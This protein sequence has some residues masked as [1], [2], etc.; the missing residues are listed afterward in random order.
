MA[1]T[2]RP[3]ILWISFE[4]SNPRF[5]CYGDP[6]ART[7]NLDALAAD[8]CV[9]NRCFSTTGVSAPSRAAII[10]GMYPT[11]AG[12][13]H[14]RTSHQ[15]KA[16]PEL[17]TPYNAVLPHYAKCFT[18]YLRSAGYYCSNNGKHDYQF[19]APITAWDH[20]NEKGTGIADWQNR[21][22]QAK[23]QPFFAV[24]NLGDT[25]ESRMWPQNCPE[26]TFDPA[27]MIVPPYFPDTLKVREAMA[28][29]YTMIEYNDGLLGNL[30][31]KL[32]ADGLTENT[33]VFV[34]SDH[35]PMPRGKRWPYDAGIHVPLIARWPGHIEKGTRN[36]ELVSTLDLGPTMLSMAGVDIPTHMQGRAFLGDQ[37]KA[38]PPREY[39]HA[40]R[41][42]YDTDYD[43][44]RAVRDK[45]FKYMRNYRPE[46]PY[47]IWVP[48]RNKHPI[49]QEM[50]RLHLAGELNEAQSVMFQHPRPP[51]ELYDT[52]TDPHEINNLAKD[53]KFAPDLQ[54]LRGELM[55]WN[56]EVGDWGE[57][58]EVE[59]VRSWKPDNVTLK[60]AAPLFIP[61]CEENPGIDPAPDGGTFAG[62]LMLQLYAATQGASIAYTFDE[63]EDAYWQ[64]Y[65][66]PFLL[67]TGST[68]VRVQADRIGYVQSDESMATFEVSIPNG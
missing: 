68:T 48:Y 5:G 57:V 28:R 29:M 61:I 37:A 22:E 14:M 47:L 19:R 42:R 2:N 62:P 26:I 33:A 23:D 54:R 4:D 9:W 17:P 27:D 39:I 8:G 64:L 58:P 11:S 40:S 55:R 3:N 43:M 52:Q 12:T 16:T 24:Y 67:P 49:T 51:E 20:S 56:E 6:V 32:D 30:L 65:A 31:K 7:P 13:L 15:D 38:T 45:R 35:G 53:P 59:M 44:V 21:P 66:K 18:E 1:Q 41:D 50:Y 46:L 60:C 25:H 63:G 34:W 10:T 36:E